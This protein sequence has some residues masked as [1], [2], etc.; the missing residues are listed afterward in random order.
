M[1]KEN[2]IALVE[3]VSSSFTKASITQKTDN[4]GSKN[5]VKL[6]EELTN[7]VDEF[8]TETHE[9]LKNI[10][11]KEEIL[12]PQSAVITHLNDQ[13]LYIGKKNTRFN[14]KKP[15]VSLK[16]LMDINKIDHSAETSNSKI[17]KRD[18]SKEKVQSYV[19]SKD[20][21]KKFASDKVDKG[22]GTEKITPENGS[23]EMEKL[24]DGFRKK[25]LEVSITQVAFDKDSIDSQINEINA[26]RTN[27]DLENEKTCGIETLPFQRV[28]IKTN[29]P[30]TYNIM[31]VGQSGLGKSTFINTLFQTQLLDTAEKDHANCEHEGTSPCV[32]TESKTTCI[33]RKTYYL[34]QDD[35]MCI[36]LTC[37]DTPGFGDY[38]N[39]QYAWGA[40]TSYINDQYTQFFL[41]ET[42]PDRAE[43]TDTR[44]HCCLY[45]IPPSIK[46]LSSLDVEAMK[47][48][49]Q[50]VTLIPVI[51]KSDGL[52][53]EETQVFLKNIRETIEKQ[54]I[55]ICKYLQDELDQDSFFKHVQK[56]IPFRVIGSSTKVL[57]SENK[58]VYGRSYRW[59]T[60]EVENPEHCDFVKLRN[61]LISEH[62]DSFFALTEQYYATWRANIVFSQNKQSQRLSFSFDLW[63]EIAHWNPVYFYQERELKKKYNNMTKCELQ[64]FKNKKKI[65]LNRQEAL[66]ED[67]N[68]LR[69]MLFILEKECAGFEAL[70]ETAK[71]E[72][73]AV[74]NDNHFENVNENG[75]KPDANTD[76]TKLSRT[77][78]FNTALGSFFSKRH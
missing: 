52:L 75:L 29:K 1:T 49:A 18:N 70:Q 38:A 72:E 77:N 10:N 67:I 12:T 56:N 8:L 69:E 27:E 63:K 9:V 15:L 25:K 7:N 32:G 57:N 6:K 78:S 44:V 35:G 66:N 28:K 47:E 68:G 21:D 34:E 14:S 26:S 4:L 37:I 64:E 22:K 73:I 19:E 24:P 51:A 58:M 62:L 30:V 45:F 40:I 17:S 42:Q 53:V 74:E 65:L 5:S 11:L 54:E 50:R 3:S 31:C 59:G 60:C 2:P 61:L 71:T 13:S 55:K 76:L 36:K 16:K 33:C 43:K 23:K 20:E 46:G 39:N 48:I 41:Q